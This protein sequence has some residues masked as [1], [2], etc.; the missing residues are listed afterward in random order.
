M[1]KEFTLKDELIHSRFP[2]KEDINEVLNVGCGG[3]RLDYHLGK[4]G[5]KVYST[6]YQ[7]QDG[8]VKDFFRKERS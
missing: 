8:W 3:G 1:T 7:N 4:M 2:K 6:D 5:Y